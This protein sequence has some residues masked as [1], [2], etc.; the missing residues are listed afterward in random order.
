MKT[1]RILLAGSALVALASAPAQAQFALGSYTA[2]ISFRDALSSTTMTLAFDGASYWSS[3]GGGPGGIR[4]ARYSNAGAVTGTFAPGLDFRS[5]FT[6]ASGTV[7]ARQFN[8]STIYRQTAPGVFTS[9]V[10]LA[11]SFDAQSAV[12]LGGGGSFYMALIG[13]TGT[14]QRWDLAGNALSSVVLSGFG[15]MF[16]ENVYPQNRGIADADGYWLTYSNGNLSAWDATTGNRLDTATLVAGGSSFDSNFSISFANC[17][18]FVVDGAGG[19]WRGYDVL[20][21]GAAEECPGPTGP[22]A[23]TPEPITMTL[24]GTG[25]AGIAAARRRR[26]QA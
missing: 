19:T 10:V 11:G 26:R 20:G 21:Q 8:N 6:D 23:V 24:M 14:V 16:G 5:V 25:L 12:T 7:Y 22:G 15:S 13:G 2:D 3:S 9:H 18:A 17:R 4:E 1:I